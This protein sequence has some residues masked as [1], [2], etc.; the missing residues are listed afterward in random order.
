MNSATSLRHDTKGRSNRPQVS[1][2]RAMNAANC[3]GWPALNAIQRVHVHAAEQPRGVHA[4]VDVGLLDVVVERGAGAR[5][6][7]AVAGGVDHHLGHDGHA[8]FLALEDHALDRAALDDR[9]RR[10]RVVD[11][12]DAALEHQLLAQQLQPLGVDRRRPGHHAVVG[13]GALRP[14]RGLRSGPA[15]PQSARAVR[16][17]RRRAGGRTTPRRSRGSP[18]CLPSRSCGRSRS[19]GRRWTARRGGCSA[20]AA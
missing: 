17:P 7:V 10:P 5:E 16:P 15:M 11:Q 18:A 2:P 8:A 20:R 19:P 14:V 12:L 1:R 9:L 4:V 3:S 13:G 6:Q